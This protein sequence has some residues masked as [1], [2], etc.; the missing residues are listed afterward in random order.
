LE[1]AGSVIAYAVIDEIE[2]PSFPSGGAFID[3]NRVLY[4]GVVQSG[5]SLVVEVVTGAAAS[6]RVAPEQVRFTDMIDGDPSN[7]VGPHTP[8]RSQPWRLWYRVEKTD[9]K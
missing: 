8:S 2:V 5:E 7:W 9:P 3:L 1:L 6:G 4:E